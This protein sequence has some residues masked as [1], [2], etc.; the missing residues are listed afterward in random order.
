MDMTMHQWAD[1]F[2]VA[3]GLVIFVPPVAYGLFW[4]VVGI[5][6]ML[7]VLFEFLVAIIH[8]LFMLLVWSW[9]KHILG[10]GAVNEPKS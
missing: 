7:G 6:K 2:I 9:L 5:L 10:R 4:I 1:F 3:I 8:D